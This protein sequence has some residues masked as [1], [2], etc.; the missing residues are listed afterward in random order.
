MH[1]VH[2]KTQKLSPFKF[3]TF[4]L[5]Y[6]KTAQ[7]R[8]LILIRRRLIFSYNWRMFLF[9]LPFIYRLFPPLKPYLQ[10]LRTLALKIF[11]TNCKLVFI[12]VIICLTS[13]NLHI[14]F[15]VIYYI[16]LF[17][18]WVVL[19]VCLKLARTNQYFLCFEMTPKG[20]FTSSSAKARIIVD[21]TQLPKNVV[22]EKY[23][24]FR[25]TTDS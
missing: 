13:S 5:F 11:S 9:S 24:E 22:D 6:L 7:S 8:L 17:I 20:N 23:V 14:T 19:T 4:R 1:I 3:L 25:N 12:S 18:S 21:F 10:Y 15:L 16:Y 2:L